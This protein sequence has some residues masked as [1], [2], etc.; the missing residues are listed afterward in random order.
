MEQEIDDLFISDKSVDYTD[1]SIEDL[2]KNIENFKTII[3]YIDLIKNKISSVDTNFEL[4]NVK[5]EKLATEMKNIEEENTKLENEIFY[6]TSIYENLKDLLL[7][8]QLKEEHFIT[9][10]TETFTNQGLVKIE[11]AIENLENFS[12]ENYTIRVVKEKKNRINET[13]EKFYKKFVGYIANLLEN[14]QI[15]TNFQV[16]TELYKKLEKYKFLYKM[17]EKYEKNYTNLCDLYINY[18]KV[19][20][21]AEL[22]EYLKRLLDLNKESKKPENIEQTINTI[23]ETYKLLI[24]VESNFLKS[25]SIKRD[26]KEIFNNSN[27]KIVNFLKDLYFILPL[28]T[29]CYTNKNLEENTENEEIFYK[30]FI[31]DLKISVLGK[32]KKQFLQKEAELR[33]KEKGIAR[34]KN[35]IKL[36]K[37]EDFNNILYRI[38][39]SRI[40]RLDN[41][42]NIWDIIDSKRGLFEINYKTNDDIYKEADKEINK[43]LEKSVIDFVFEHGELKR[44]INYLKNGIKGS[45]IFVKNMKEQVYEIIE[46]NLN[47]KEK[48]E[49][50]SILLE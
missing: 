16:H 30:N 44:Q 47:D 6:Q 14:E 36:S 17:S 12:A 3:P 32:L 48:E 29:V 40:L 26:I 35:F 1:K 42:S 10:E 41:E 37:M 21:N 25:M 49:V 2:N 46:N 38:N 5:L 9:L 7:K 8:L 27:Q 45:A 31:E 11:E 4:Y 22:T 43:R 18:S 19:R 24:H 13:L 50:K 15:G 34:F 23:F 28:E 33:D 39:I 20:Y